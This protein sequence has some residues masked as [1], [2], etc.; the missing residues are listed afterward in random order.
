MTEEQR[1]SRARSIGRGILRV[2][3]PFHAMRQTVH[4]AK[5]EAQRT[6]DNV[7]ILRD[8]ATQ[9]RRSL[10]DSQINSAN[11]THTAEPAEE[12]FDEAIARRGPGALPIPILRRAFL[13]K[14][15]TALVMALIFLL[16][17][18][19]QIA[20]GVATF[21]AGAVFFGLLSLAGSQ[22]LCFVLALSAHFRIWQIDNRRLSRAEKGGFDDFRQEVP[23]WWLTVLNPELGH[24][25]RGET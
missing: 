12:S 15:R 1:P 5:Q 25:H 17:A 20:W 2:M 23:R 16:T 24:A 14:K 21:S 8:L 6:K 3:L 4:L 11:D 7:V 13:R 19:T 9:A 18:L 22:P 10:T